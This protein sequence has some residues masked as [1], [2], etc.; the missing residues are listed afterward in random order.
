VLLVC[1]SSITGPER[2]S[3]STHAQSET[4]SEGGCNAVRT[5]RSDPR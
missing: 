4:Q 5:Y 3:P 1:P 2:S